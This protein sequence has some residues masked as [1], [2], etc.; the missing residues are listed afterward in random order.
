[1]LYT[2]IKVTHVGTATLSFGLMV[3]RG[4]WMWR[5]P[6][7]LRA[8][9]VRVVPHVIDTLLLVSAI[10]LSILSS[11]YPLVDDWL[12]AKVLLLLLYIGLGTVA[13]KRGHTLRTRLVCW[14]LALLTL[15]VIAG[16]AVTRGALLGI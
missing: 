7:R 13:L 4:W 2:W 6:Q 8:G 3:L 11:Q 16:T 12:T 14:L 15:A 10:T 9:W 5:T 1:M